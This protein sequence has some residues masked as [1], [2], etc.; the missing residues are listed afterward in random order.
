[1]GRDS[2][3]IV[4]CASARAAASF[5]LNVQSPFGVDGVTPPTHDVERVH[6]RSGMV[7]FCFF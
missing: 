6:K 3:V 1:M 2:C 5:S 7:P 4:L